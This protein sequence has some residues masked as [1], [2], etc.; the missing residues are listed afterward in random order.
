[1]RTIVTV[2]C[3]KPTTTLLDYE[4]TEAT[5]DPLHFAI[6]GGPYFPAATFQRGRRNS[7]FVGVR[8]NIQPCPAA[9]NF[10]E[11][12]VFEV[13]S[14]DAPAKNRDSVTETE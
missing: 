10:S 3:R 8:A 11:Q 2:D 14:K 9:E 12:F 13:T 6:L 1:M 7:V 5:N 4:I